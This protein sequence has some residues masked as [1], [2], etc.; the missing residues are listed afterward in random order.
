MAAVVQHSKLCPAKT[1]EREEEVEP[2][3]F[4]RETTLQLMAERALALTRATGAAI[5]LSEG[6]DSEMV[7]VASA[8][9]DAPPFGTPAACGFRIFR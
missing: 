7:C 4:D 1:R 5:A 8:G 2:N 9:S 6:N 3:G